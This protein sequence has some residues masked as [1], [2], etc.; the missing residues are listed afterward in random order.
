[1]ADITWERKGRRTVVFFYADCL[2]E[3]LCSIWKYKLL[4][5]AL[6]SYCCSWPQ[7]TK[8]GL[9]SVK[10]TKQNIGDLVIYKEH[11][12]TGLMV[13]EVGKPK[14]IA[15]AS[16]WPLGR[17]P[18]CITMW[19]RVSRV[20]QDTDISSHLSVTLPWVSPYLRPHL[21]SITFQT[22]PPNYNQV[23]EVS[24]ESLKFRE[25]VH[26]GREVLWICFVKTPP[27]SISIL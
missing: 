21:I 17:I 6:L 20:G 18:P 24:F 8:I 14:S 25:H 10:T 13:L 2:W 5:S 26:S 15:L 11:Y 4:D 19:W 7:T 16:A 3:P 27:R 12:F 23:S 1:M 9:F 22:L